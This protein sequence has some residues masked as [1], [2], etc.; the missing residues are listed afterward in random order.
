VRLQITSADG[1]EQH[2]VPRYVLGSSKPIWNGKLKNCV[3]VLGTNALED[4][5]FCI[6]TNKGGKIMPEGVAEPSEQNEDRTV[7]I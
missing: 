3:M 4:L 1:E 5:G 7:T 6:V 2:Q